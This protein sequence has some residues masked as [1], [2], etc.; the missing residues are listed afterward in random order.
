M[1]RS[2]RRAARIQPAPRG[3]SAATPPLGEEKTRR[4]V[5]RQRPSLTGRAC[6][7]PAFTCDELHPDWRSFYLRWS[8]LFRILQ[9]PRHWI[10]LALVLLSMAFLIGRLT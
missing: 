6:D 8:S 4:I 3:R 10:V 1:N 5:V 7:P 2:V 9:R